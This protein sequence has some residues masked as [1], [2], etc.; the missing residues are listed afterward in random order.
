MGGR[1]GRSALY[2]DMRL[3]AK[4]KAYQS[5]I[6]KTEEEWKRSTEINMPVE[7]RKRRE[8]NGESGACKQQKTDL[9]YAAGFF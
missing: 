7:S 4:E 2:G 8:W 1:D 5:A 3:N 6:K 9:V